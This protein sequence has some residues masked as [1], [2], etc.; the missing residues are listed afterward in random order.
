MHCYVPEEWNQS[1]S[2]ILSYTSSSWYLFWLSLVTF[3]LCTNSN[4]KNVCCMRVA[5]LLRVMHEQ[6][7]MQWNFLVSRFPL[8]DVHFQWFQLHPAFNVLCNFAL[9]F[10]P[11]TQLP[12]PPPP[13][14]PDG[15]LSNRFS[16]YCGW[17]I[18]ELWLEEVENSVSRARH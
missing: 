18:L 9:K 8:C 10:F 5:T 7:H 13:P 12:P 1:S 2:M 3:Q 15:K 11:L 4:L 14:L 6:L 17:I 16:L